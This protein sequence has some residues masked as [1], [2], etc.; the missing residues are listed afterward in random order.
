MKPR[1]RIGTILYW[2]FGGS[3]TSLYGLSEINGWERSASAYERIEPTVRHVASG[4]G[5]SF[6][7]SGSH[8]GK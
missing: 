4:G 3:L 7:Y 5:S 8:G 1:L 6:W 2:L